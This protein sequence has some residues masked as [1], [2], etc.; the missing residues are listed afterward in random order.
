MRAPFHPHVVVIGRIVA[1]VAMLNMAGWLLDYRPLQDLLPGQPA[2]TIFTSTSL[3][4]SGILLMRIG[5]R[6]THPDALQMEIFV[7]TIYQCTLV[8][9]AIFIDRFT[10]GG[11]QVS[12]GADTWLARS[13]VPSL[14]TAANVALIAGAMILTVKNA[15][16]WGARVCVAAAVL[17]SLGVVIGHFA[18][19]RVLTG[20]WPQTSR[21]V[22]LETALA[23]LLLAYGC[24]SVLDDG[25]RV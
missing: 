15:W 25:E 4:V 13:G 19:V 23:Y 10:Y 21:P 6:A 22:A 9:A 2:M 5:V 16:R 17:I 14:L 18:G 3:M 11:P 20:D 1:F 7:G 24:W 12:H 8:A